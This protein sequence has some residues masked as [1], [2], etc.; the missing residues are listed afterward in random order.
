FFAAFLAGAFLAAFFVAFFFVVL[1]TVRPPLMTFGDCWAN[2]L[3][4]TQKP[5][6]QS[7]M[8]TTAKIASVQ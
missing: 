2:C 7:Q 1:A 3:P 6:R 8:T 4:H 5:T